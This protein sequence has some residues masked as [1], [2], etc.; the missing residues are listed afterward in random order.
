MSRESFIGA[1]RKSLLEI[2]HR[3][4]HG[5]DLWDDGRGVD[6]LCDSVSVLT[7]TVG[8]V[9]P[10]VEVFECEAM[11]QGETEGVVGYRV[12]GCGGF[13]GSGA[14]PAGNWW[15]RRGWRWRCENLE[16][17]EAWELSPTFG[18]PLAVTAPVLDSFSDS[19]QSIDQK[20]YDECED[21]ALN[22]AG[23]G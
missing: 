8:K 16:S 6:T 22:S 7:R 13:R 11:V 17:G 9:S 20:D 19:V 5:W 18:I 1:N 3:T 12:C 23:S 2:D 15:S 10:S 21:G 4:F 14:W